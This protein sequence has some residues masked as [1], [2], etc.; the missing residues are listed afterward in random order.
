MNAALSSIPPNDITVYRLEGKLDMHIVFVVF[1]MMYE[2]AIPNIYPF[3]NEIHSNVKNFSKN[4]QNR[5]IAKLFK[6]IH[7]NY[8]IN[9][10]KPPDCSYRR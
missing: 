1:T 2:V 4:H 10:K 6:S 7:N 3:K 9:T 8:Y 5:P